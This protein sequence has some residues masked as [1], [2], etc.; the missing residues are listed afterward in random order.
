MVFCTIISYHFYSLMKMLLPKILG[1]QKCKDQSYDWNRLSLSYQY[2]SS[3]S[4]Q[5]FCY[6]EFL[7]YLTIKH[8][9][10]IWQFNNNVNSIKFINLYEIPKFSIIVEYLFAWREFQISMIIS[11]VCL[12]P[13]F[14]YHEATFIW[15]FFRIQILTIR[16][17]IL[18]PEIRVPRNFSPMYLCN[19]NFIVYCSE[20]C[21]KQAHQ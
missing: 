11:I 1:K 2:C 19:K 17:K 5:V 21:F 6:T 13:F 8:K 18:N 3:F 14:C 20:E 7:D 4:I 16:T 15:F 9:K 12:I 10:L